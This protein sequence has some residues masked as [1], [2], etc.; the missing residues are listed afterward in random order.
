MVATTGV[1]VKAGLM[2]AET[3]ALL[4]GAALLTML[5]MPLIGRIA[6]R[7]EV[8]D[9]GDAVPEFRRPY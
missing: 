7:P 3:A 4:V 2:F 1:A 9:A 8:P 6:A 5:V